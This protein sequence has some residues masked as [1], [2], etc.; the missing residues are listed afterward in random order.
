M[1][2]P[3]C[4]AATIARA[5]F[6]GA[7]LSAQYQRGRSPFPLGI[8]RRI[9]KGQH[10]SD[11]QV[12]KAAMTSQQGQCA[13][14][15]FARGLSA[16]SGKCARW[17]LRPRAILSTTRVFVF[18]QN[19]ANIPRQSLSFNEARAVKLEFWVKTRPKS[20]DTSPFRLEV[21]RP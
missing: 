12:Y 21:A 11:W 8:L 15:P 4:G 2:R 5:D 3:S 16:E 14:R 18:A 19:E 6:H 1:A 17:G 9:R 13:A 10:E 20:W 7:L